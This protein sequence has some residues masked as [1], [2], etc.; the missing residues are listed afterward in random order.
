MALVASLA[1]LTIANTG[2]ISTEMDIAQEQNL[3]VWMP[4]AWTAATLTIQVQREGS[5]AWHTV[6]DQDNV[7]VLPAAVD[8]VL[9]LPA[10]SLLPNSARK[11]RLV[12]SV[13]QGADRT[14]VVERRAF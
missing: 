14:L 6:C 1:T 5:T 13:A 11:L 9:L 8:R 3:S 7:V 2:T 10:S 4:A 12:S